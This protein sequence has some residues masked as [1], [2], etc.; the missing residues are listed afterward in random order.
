MW[1]QN[2]QT[3]AEE[4]MQSQPLRPSAEVVPEQMQR[5]NLRNINIGNNFES[6]FHYRRGV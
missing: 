3:R 1:R 6:I 5:S 2:A 4:K